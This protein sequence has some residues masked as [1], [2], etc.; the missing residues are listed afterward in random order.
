MS[1]YVDWFFTTVLQSGS[2]AWLLI[3]VVLGGTSLILLPPFAFFCRGVSGGVVPSRLPFFCIAF[4]FWKT[5]DVWLDPSFLELTVFSGFGLCRNLMSSVSALLDLA[6]FFSCVWRFFLPK[7]KSNRDSTFVLRSW[8]AA[9]SA[10]AWL[11]SSLV[12]WDAVRAK[13]STPSA[14]AW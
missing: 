2:F 12:L 3:G 7:I 13:R 8:K 4:P 1:T 5:G 11:T 14:P 9:A 6:M 10:L